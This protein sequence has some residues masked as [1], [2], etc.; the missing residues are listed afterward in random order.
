M[1]EFYVGKDIIF[2]SWLRILRRKPKSKWSGSF[3]VKFVSP[4]GAIEL[5]EPGGGCYHL[6]GECEDVKTL[7]WRGKYY[8][9]IFYH[10]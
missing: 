4:Y 2:N 7:L 10:D 5:Y 1:R 3:E 6:Q 9:W 8:K